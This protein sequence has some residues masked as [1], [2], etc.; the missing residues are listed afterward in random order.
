MSQP[1]SVCVFMVPPG[2]AS[3]SSTVTRKPACFS[4]QAVQR[5]EMPAPTTTTCFCGIGLLP[6]SGPVGAERRA[7]CGGI[8]DFAAGAER[9][10][11][12]RPLLQDEVFQTRDER[13]AVVER[14][15]HF[16]L[17]DAEFGSLSARLDVDLVQRLDVLG[18]E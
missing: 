7:L 4:H 14:R 6:G 1:F 15:H 9:N 5:P 11:R 16:E 12:T 3:F 18:D 17:R 13:R 8:S 10:G 2:S